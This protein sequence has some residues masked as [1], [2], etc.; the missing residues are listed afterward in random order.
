MEII[1]RVDMDQAIEVYEFQKRKLS[2]ES[3]YR[4]DPAKNEFFENKRKNKRRDH[5]VDFI[6]SYKVCREI[7]KSYLNQP[8]IEQFKSDCEQEMKQAKNPVVAFLCFFEHIDGT[9]DFERYEAFEV[10][11]IIQ[12]WCKQS[13]FEYTPAVAFAPENGLVTPL[14]KIRENAKSTKRK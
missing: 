9:Y 4:F 6:C 13:N 8:G 2:D 1:V 3:L 12:K 7:I 10:T 14:I 11:K 5:C